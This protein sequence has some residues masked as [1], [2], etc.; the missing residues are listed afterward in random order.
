MTPSSLELVNESFT[1]ATL[2]NKGKAIFQI[3]QAFL[4]RYPLQTE[5]LLQP[6]QMRAFGLVVDD[7]VH[8]HMGKDGKPGGQCIEVG[9]AKYPMHFYGWKYYFQ[10]QKHNPIDLA[11]YPITELTFPMIYDPQSRYCCRFH[12]PNITVE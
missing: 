6:H 8:I 2:P 3:N 7:C 1:L 4:D 12:Q 10:I 9:N 5:A 11:K